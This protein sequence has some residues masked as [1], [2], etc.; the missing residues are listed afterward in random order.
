M[1]ERVKYYMIAL[2]A[3][4]FMNSQLYAQKE[5][6]V[7]MWEVTKVVLGEKE[8]TPISRWF[9]FNENGRQRSGNG[10]QQHSIGEYEYSAKARELSVID[11]NGVKDNN[12]PFSVN[13]EGEGMQWER[14]EEDGTVTVY[15]KKINQLPTAPADQLIGVWLLNSVTINDSNVTE[16]YSPDNRRYI[17]LRWDKQFRIRNATSGNKSGFYHVD[18]HNPLIRLFF[19]RGSEAEEWKFEV[20]ENDLQLFKAD[21]K[22]E[23]VRKYK[24]VDY[25]P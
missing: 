20:S 6:V 15:L 17:H 21:A 19:N 4:I 2:L 5:S 16:A 23:V 1:N 7:G 9:E 8:M 11:A 22:E 14:A 13:F 12:P 3:I 10:W 25:F 24:R 18:A